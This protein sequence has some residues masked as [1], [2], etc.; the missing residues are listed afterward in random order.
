[1]KFFSQS[2][3]YDDPWSIVTLAFFLRYPNPYA[4]HV[5][6]CDVISRSV[7][8]S[9]SLMTTRLIL[10]RGAMPRWFPKGIV[11][12]AE[13]WVVEESEVDPVGRTV[14]CKTTNL[15]HIKVM[16][17]EETVVFRSAP[18][19][20]TLQLTEARIRSG[21]G[22][23]LTKRIENHGLNKF[24]ANVQRSREGVSL[25]VQLLR[26]SR[27][28][29]MALGG[30]EDASLAIRLQAQPTPPEHKTAT[31]TESDAQ[32]A[33]PIPRAQ[34]PWSRLKAW[35]HPPPRTD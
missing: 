20:K 22:W 8:P 28:Q 4:S 13:T 12:R 17:V 23:G 6:S 29:P 2:Y 33:C 25:I 35:L 14:K 1:M 7:S 10:K 9:G 32:T 5:L 21:F 27:L 18:E 15:D 16:Q 26:Q 24:K 19:G 31:G 30:P 11:S 3:S 34:N